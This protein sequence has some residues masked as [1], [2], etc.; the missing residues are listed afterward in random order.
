[1]KIRPTIDIQPQG[2]GKRYCCWTK[3]EGLNETTT[4]CKWAQA[5]QSLIGHR[6]YCRIFE[7]PCFIDDRNRVLRCPQCVAAEKETEP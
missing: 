2:P 5:M 6:V 7:T 4:W 3:G 1:M